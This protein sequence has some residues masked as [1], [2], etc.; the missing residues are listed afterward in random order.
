VES[1]K[2]IAIETLHELNREEVE[3]LLDK[4]DDIGANSLTED[5]RAF[6]DR[7]AAN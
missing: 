7:M 3:R 4:V 5:E 1:W 6:M 2:Q